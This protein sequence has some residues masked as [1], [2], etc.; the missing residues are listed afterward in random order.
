MSRLRPRPVSNDPRP[1]WKRLLYR[2]L[3]FIGSIAGVL[4]LSF[5]FAYLFEPQWLLRMDMMRKAMAANLDTHSIEA[6]DTKWSYYEG[7]NGPTLVLLHGFAANKDVWLDSAK[8]LTKNFHVIAPDLPGWGD[9]S[10]VEGGRYDVDSQV[11]RLD[12][13]FDRMGLRGFTLVGHSMG[14]AIAGTY[15]ADHPGRVS[16]L[17]LMDTLGLTFKP[18]DFSKAA[19]NGKDPFVFDDRAGFEAMLN[20]VFLN[21]PKVPGRIADAFVQQNKDNRA[22]IEHTFDELKPESQSLALDSRLPKLTVPVLGLWCH[23]D[24]V[25]DISAL[26]TLR[27]GLTN[28]RA[29][30]TTILNGCN[31]MPQIEKPDEFAKVITGFVMAH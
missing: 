20:L 9:S 4:A 8:E 2:R 23:D 21:P 17:V 1:L 24:K 13:F 7:G 26:D 5:A 12:T 22:F 18:N 25:I 14:G 11:A 10:R 29:I 31:H 28:A 16:N 3:K 30:S 15:A 27:N 19:L 6:G